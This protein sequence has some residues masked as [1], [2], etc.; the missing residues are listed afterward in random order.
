MIER[1]R[2]ENFANKLKFW[3]KIQGEQN[4]YL[5][6]YALLEHENNLDFPGKKYYYL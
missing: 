6:A 3:G 2:E 5:I 1:Q 4:D